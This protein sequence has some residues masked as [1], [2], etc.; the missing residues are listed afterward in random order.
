MPYY[1]DVQITEPIG[2]AVRVRFLLVRYAVIDSAQIYNVR[3][4]GL[5][6]YES[7]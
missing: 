7:L 1:P 6:I 5:T 4:V 3:K 2:R